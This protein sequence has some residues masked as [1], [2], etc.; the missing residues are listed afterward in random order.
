MIFHLRSYSFIPHEG[1]F[2][3]RRV[4]EEE[5]VRAVSK[6]IIKAGIRHRETFRYVKNLLGVKFI[7]NSFDNINLLNKNEILYTIRKEGNNG[8]II[9]EIK[10][11]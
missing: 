4:S 8:F 10:S 6:G 5:F 7:K 2:E 1:V 9:W 11:R 3:V